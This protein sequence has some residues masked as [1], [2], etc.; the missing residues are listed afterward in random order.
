MAAFTLTGLFVSIAL[1]FVTSVVVAPAVNI[2]LN[3]ASQKLFASIKSAKMSTPSLAV[4]SGVAFSGSST[5]QNILL[6]TVNSTTFVLT[7][8]AEPANSTANTCSNA[9]PT[10]L[11][12]PQIDTTESP[13]GSP[14][15][16]VLKGQSAENSVP[17]LNLD[18][19]H[20]NTPLITASPYAQ[21]EGLTFSKGT[22]LWQPQAGA[23]PALQASFQGAPAII[24]ESSFARNEGL[25]FAAG[26]SMWQPTS[27]ATARQQ[28]SP[29]SL[30][31]P[32]NAGEWKTKSSAT[33]SM[34]PMTAPLPASNLITQ[35]PF[36]FNEGL[37]IPAGTSMWQ[38]GSAAAFKTPTSTGR[39]SL[40][41]SSPYDCNETVTFPKGTL[42]WQPKAKAT[43]KTGCLTRFARSCM[44]FFASV[45]SAVH[46]KLKSV[47]KAS[48]CALV[49]IVT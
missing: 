10:L 26:I 43:D 33:L 17:A 4:P 5:Q 49:S 2:I 48:W 8:P 31:T 22:S 34:R 6:D 44:R 11:M 19:V 46:N 36:C 37:K 38:P 24:S 23:K 3:T 13:I 20:M 25:K 12:V 41:T 9:M 18:N 42:L 1:A 14:S 28:A 40:I 15:T 35:S 47:G 32:A 39:P 45:L 21:N 30:W 27:S 16:P 29:P 7:T